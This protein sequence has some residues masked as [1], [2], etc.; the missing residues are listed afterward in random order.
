MDKVT[1][2]QQIVRAYLEEYANTVKPINLQGVESK[3]IADTQMNSFQL[4]RIGWNGKQNIFNVVLHFDII[5][6]KIWMQ[7]NNTDREVVDVLMEQ[8]VEKQD[9]V[10]GFVPPEARGYLGFAEA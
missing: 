5:N 10:L 3:V 9:I 2:Y 1:K 4:V 6:S 7:C 8:G